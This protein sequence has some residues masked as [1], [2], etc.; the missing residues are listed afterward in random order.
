MNREYINELVKGFDNKI[1]NKIELCDEM[2]LV[3]RFENLIDQENLQSYHEFIECAKTLKK[4]Y[5]IVKLILKNIQETNDYAI[6]RLYKEFKSCS[7]DVLI[8][9]E[10]SLKYVSEGMFL[11]VVNDYK[12]KYDAVNELIEIYYNIK[13]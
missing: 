2:L 1:D 9:F 4:A 13:K 6:D 12:E 5:F 3:Q 8:G 11:S 10:N 7:Q